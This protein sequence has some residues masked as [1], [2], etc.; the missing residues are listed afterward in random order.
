MIIG[1]TLESTIRE[2][3]NHHCKFFL[4]NDGN[5]YSRVI[6]PTTNS[7]YTQVASFEEADNDEFK[8]IYCDIISG[9]ADIDLNNELTTYTKSF[10]IYNGPNK[11]PFN[12]TNNDEC[13]EEEEDEWI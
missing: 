11:V 7:H 2:L 10:R 12:I 13:N 3:K 8:L 1:L 6:A 5:G 9:V 4:F